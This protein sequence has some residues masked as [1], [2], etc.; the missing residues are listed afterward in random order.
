M[1]VLTQKYIL[2]KTW[3][4]KILMAEHSHHENEFEDEESLG[5]TAPWN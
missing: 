3:C 5:I 2:K 4:W 1:L